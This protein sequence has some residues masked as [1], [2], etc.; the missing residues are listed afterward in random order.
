LDQLITE[1]KTVLKPTFSLLLKPVLKNNL[2]LKNDL[3][4]G[5][6]AVPS[7][8]KEHDS[9]DII[10]FEENILKAYKLIDFLYF[11]HGYTKIKKNIFIT[12]IPE[13][14]RKTNTT[15][16]CQQNIL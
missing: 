11:K 7:G 9:S 4:P 3:H 5:L 12:S 15:Q 1:T 14:R 8:I 13:S 2:Y 10:K 6:K 16:I